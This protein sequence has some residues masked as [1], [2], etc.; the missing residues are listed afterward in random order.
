M[1]SF[2]LIIIIADKWQEFFKMRT[3]QIW[4]VWSIR[5]RKNSSH[6][7]L[8]YSCIA[9][10]FNTHRELQNKHQQRWGGGFSNNLTKVLLTLQLQLLF[11]YQFWKQLELYAHPKRKTVKGHLCLPM[12]ADS[13]GGG[14]PEDA[15]RACRARG[16]HDFLTNSSK[17][18]APW[19]LAKHGTP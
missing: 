17:V 5:K 1:K 7:K 2:S 18:A 19:C 4:N 15:G 10:E 14:R 12:S 8:C 9:H 6:G 3:K 16:L 13:A 11:L